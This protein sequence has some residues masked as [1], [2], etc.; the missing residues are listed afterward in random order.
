MKLMK[1]IIK[2]LNRFSDK[3]QNFTH[4][5]L[6]TFHNKIIKHKQLYYI[7]GAVNKKASL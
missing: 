1:N 5:D 3:I 4:K 2:K 6:D 7:Y